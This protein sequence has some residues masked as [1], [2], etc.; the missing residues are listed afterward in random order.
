VKDE[1]HEK[2]KKVYF[3]KILVMFLV[4]LVGSKKA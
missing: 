3:N 1:K 2:L 4:F